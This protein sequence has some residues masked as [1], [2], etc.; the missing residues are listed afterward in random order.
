MLVANMSRTEQMLDFISCLVGQ[1]SPAW[2]SGMRMCTWGSP[3]HGRVAVYCAECPLFHRRV[4][5]VVW[6]SASLHMLIRAA[7]WHQRHDL[8]TMSTVKGLTPEALCK[9]AVERGYEFLGRKQLARSCILLLY[10]I[11]MRC[12]G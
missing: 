4:S 10:N 8:G 9:I 1:L 6:I 7:V 12:S 5:A 2:T 11:V 3:Q